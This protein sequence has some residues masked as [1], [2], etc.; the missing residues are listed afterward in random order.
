MTRDPAARP[1][2]GEFRGV[3]CEMAGAPGRPRV[4]ARPIR[5]ARAVCASDATVDGLRD[6]ELHCERVVWKRLLSGM[7]MALNMLVKAFDGITLQLVPD[8]G[9]EADMLAIVLERSDP[10]LTLPLYL[11][12][13][14]DKA[15]A[16][17]RAWSEVLGELLLL[18]NSVVGSESAQ[19]R[20]LRI[21]RPRPRRRRRS[22][23]KK[24]H[25][26]I[27]MRRGF[28]KIT[29][30]T[31]VHRGERE[32]VA[33]NRSEL[34]GNGAGVTC[35]AAGSAWCRTDPSRCDRNRPCA[36]CIRCVRR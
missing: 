20:H 8:E 34:C 12:S 13:R 26:S 6:F 17:W 22:T 1:G 25:P 32:I 30:A 27:L 36:A 3:K 28:G 9:G 24:R 21:E 15:L 19:L 11:T 2:A 10:S 33:R 29:R 23:L 35:S 14:P 18:A 7:R 31:P 16:E 5:P 4:A